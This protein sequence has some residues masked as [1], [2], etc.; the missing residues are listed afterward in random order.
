MKSL[1]SKLSPLD[2]IRY[3]EAEIIRN[4]ALARDEAQ[5]IESQARKRA[6]QMIAE[7]RD[8][9]RNEGEAHRREMTS[10]A[11]E[12]ARAINAQAKNST[13]ELRRKGYNRMDIAV[14]Q[15]VGLICGLDQTREEW[16]A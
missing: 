11:E 1:E 6:K 9:G 7:A 12:E 4:M 8:L 16:P 3:S 5:R 13:T 2:Q 14:N 15:L 10:V